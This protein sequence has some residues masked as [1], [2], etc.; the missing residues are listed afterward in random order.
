MDGVQRGGSPLA[1]PAR[2]HAD[3]GR[4]RFV[5][6]GVVQRAVYDAMGTAGAGRMAVFRGA[7]RPAVRLSPGLSRALARGRCGVR[8]G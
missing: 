6:P 8:Q 5:C 4:P 7:A 2:A 3:T 1:M